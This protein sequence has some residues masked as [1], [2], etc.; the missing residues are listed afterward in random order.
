MTERLASLEQRLEDHESRC[1]ER[2]GE[3]KAT[4]AR[5]LRAIEALKGRFW[6][7]TVALLAWALAQVWAGGQA[8]VAP[9]ETARAAPV[10]EVAHV[11]AR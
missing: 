4:A 7:I 8:R 1:E 6:T 5:T 3:V 11:A 9:L 2:L 10:G